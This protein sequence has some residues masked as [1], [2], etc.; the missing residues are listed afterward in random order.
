[1][2][3]SHAGHAQAERGGFLLAAG[4][5]QGVETSVQVDPTR[6]SAR[7]VEY[8]SDFDVEAG[9]ALRSR[10]ALAPVPER[11]QLPDAH[12][13]RGQPRRAGR[14][15]PSRLC[16]T[17][18]TTDSDDVETQHDLCENLKE[19][20]IPVPEHY[21]APALHRR[22][23]EPASQAAGVQDGR[24]PARL[25]RVRGAGRP[26]PEPRVAAPTRSQGNI[27]DGFDWTRAPRLRPERDTPDGT[28]DHAAR[29][30][31]GDDHVLERALPAH[32][33]SGPQRRGRMGRP[34][35][36]PVRQHRARGPRRDQGQ[37]H[38]GGAAER[39]RLHAADRRRPRRR[40]QRLHGQ[41]PRVHDRGTTTARR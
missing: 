12:D 13:G 5:G 41:L 23:G 30:T 19:H 20:G 2:K 10:P 26:D 38:E 34:R 28:C 33:G 21:D 18:C 4:R 15:G 9:N 29:C 7:F 35:E 11:F 8:S 17:A 39:A 37:L 31:A 40:L 36:R 1:M 22:R 24:G 32:G 16:A 6:S 14:A 27:W 25:V 3:W